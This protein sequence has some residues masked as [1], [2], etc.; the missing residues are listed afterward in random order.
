MIWFFALFFAARA[1]TLPS[2]WKL[3]QY[4]GVHQAW[5]NPQKP[6]HMIVLTQNKTPQ[7]MSFKNLTREQIATGLSA[8]RQLV[9]AQL[10]F[11][12]W[13]LREFDFVAGASDKITMQGS[14]KRPGNVAVQFY[15]NQFFSGNHYEQVSYLIESPRP[16]TNLKEINAL[17]NRLSQGNR[18][19]AQADDF[20]GT[21]VDCLLPQI[22]D[23]RPLQ[24][25]K[26][27]IAEITKATS[28][29]AKD[30]WL[31]DPTKKS[32]F[33]EKGFAR[34]TQ[35][36][37][38]VA[39][40]AFLTCNYG[41]LSGAG[42]SFRDVVMA[43]PSLMGLTWRGMKSGGQALMNIEY[44][45]W[46]QGFSVQKIKDSAG[47]VLTVSK[48][49]VAGA[50]NAASAAVYNSFQE[51]GVTGS[52]AAVT[53]AAYNSSPHHAVGHFLAK[54]GSEIYSAV[55]TEWSALACME[56]EALSQAMC[57]IAGYLAIDIV[58]GKLILSGLSKSGQMKGAIA[59]VRQKME[60]VPLAGDIITRN[61][62]TVEPSRCNKVGESD[63]KIDSGFKLQGQD[64]NVFREGALILARGISPKTGKLDCF[65]VQGSLSSKITERLVATE[66][67]AESKSLSGQ[68]D[69]FSASNGTYAR[70]TDEFI[71]GVNDR[72]GIEISGGQSK[73]LA[74]SLSQNPDQLERYGDLTRAVD[75]MKQR[76]KLPGMSADQNL[77]LKKV[78]TSSEESLKLINSSLPTLDNPMLF[79]LKVLKEALQ[80]AAVTQ[81]P[82]TI[83]LM[84]R[85]LYEFNKAAKKSGGSSTKAL[86]AWENTLK[87]ERKHLTSK[88]ID[89]ARSCLFNPAGTR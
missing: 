38:E 59:K 28:Q 74:S 82:E 17:L 45:N 67:R 56:P 88:D 57:E 46:L 63:W 87:I 1:Q 80:E 50:F 40:R 39:A 77:E 64:L 20:D 43:V 30:A 31:F 44:K 86:E 35:S 34:G 24:Q 78:I 6:G 18:T 79:N 47:G 60:K 5:V 22:E 42:K 73:K 23:L 83:L 3:V 10:G 26:N 29:C 53:Q 51:G 62:K 4:P 32:I 36:R 15:E 69:F 49:K 19:P 66:K 58:T 12:D 75:D 84:N 55:A 2:G 8:Y 14:Y 27:Q 72:A 48:D 85:A 13:K 89:R 16:P 37:A 33:S 54:V 70:S 11:T 7:S 61:L 52:I 76:A 25:V 9:M 68:S 71:S 65:E 81:K 41:V 21:C